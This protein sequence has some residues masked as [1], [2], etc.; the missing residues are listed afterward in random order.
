MLHV[1]GTDCAG[2]DA[3]TISELDHSMIESRGP[4][5]QERQIQTIFECGG[6]LPNR[7][8]E[9]NS[10][11]LNTR[12]VTRICALTLNLGTVTALQ[13][14]ALRS[15]CSADVCMIVYF[16]SHEVSLRKP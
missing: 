9:T 6:V 10:I 11:L 4:L 14:A 2:D 12:C 5:E 1:W 7:L 3:S 15:R 13:K 16:L 8:R